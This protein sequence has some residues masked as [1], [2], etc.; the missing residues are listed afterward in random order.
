ML[1][2]PESI[3]TIFLQRSKFTLV[4]PIIQ[5]CQSPSTAWMVLL[6]IFPLVGWGRARAGVFTW[7]FQPWEFFS[8]TVYNLQTKRVY[9]SVVTATAVLWWA[10]RWFPN[11]HSWLLCSLLCPGTQLGHLQTVMFSSVLGAGEF[12]SS[13]HYRTL[14]P[15]V[16]SCTSKF[17]PLLCC[18]LLSYFSFEHY[19]H[20]SGSQEKY[21]SNLCLCAA[22]PLTFH[23]FQ[24]SPLLFLH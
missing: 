7:L 6:Q 1:L 3:T 9:V 16:A 19:I 14:V 10:V 20:S 15:L 13:A 22:L 8:I 11:C 4:P 24:P 5:L 23:L 18:A 2:F 21:C 17:L 12:I